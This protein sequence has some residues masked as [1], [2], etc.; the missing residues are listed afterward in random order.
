M[1]WMSMLLLNSCDILSVAHICVLPKRNENTIPMDFTYR[2]SKGKNLPVDSK[3][4]VN[5]YN[6]TTCFCIKWRPN[7]NYV[8]EKLPVES[9]VFVPKTFQLLKIRLKILSF[10]LISHIMCIFYCLIYLICEHIVFSL[11][12]AIGHMVFVAHLRE[13]KS[14]STLFITGKFTVVKLSN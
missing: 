8:A 13:V 10:P 4:L 1:S 9:A 12:Y 14:Q 7:W 6:F 5:E 2:I 11:I 3:G